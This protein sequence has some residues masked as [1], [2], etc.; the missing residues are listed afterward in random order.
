MIT[1]FLAAGVAIVAL[2]VPAVQAAPACPIF[3]SFFSK[4]QCAFLV[5]T[6]NG[7][8][9]VVKQN[10]VGFSTGLNL[11]IQFQDGDDNRAYTGQKGTNEVA[12]TAQT[13]NGNTAGTHQLGT[14]IAAVTV[15]TGTGNMWSTTGMSGNGGVVT[16]LQSN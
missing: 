8:S 16:S 9:S 6:G 2:G 14:N 5:T 7:N 4:V 10:Q 15:Q 11:A 3:L 12:L 13:G 1:R